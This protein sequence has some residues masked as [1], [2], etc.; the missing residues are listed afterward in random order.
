MSHFWPQQRKNKGRGVIWRDGGAFNY[1]IFLPTEA[2][3]REGELIERDTRINKALTVSQLSVFK[4]VSRNAACNTPAS[5]S[6]FPL[7]FTIFKPLL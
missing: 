2:I 7:V 5:T 1:K 6:H 3:S 4:R